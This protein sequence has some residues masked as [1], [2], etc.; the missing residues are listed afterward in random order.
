MGQRFLFVCDACGYSAFVCGGPDAGMLVT[1]ST[2]RC[3]G[4]SQVVDVPLR[5]RDPFSSLPSQTRVARCS[6]C[7]GTKLE[8]WGLGH[9]HA[10]ESDDPFEPKRVPSA[11]ERWG[12]CPKCGGGMRSN[13]MFELSD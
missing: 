1:V 6:K 12:D 2:M 8:P 7:G 11:D 5:V 4:C 3:E 10:Q 9:V 13:G